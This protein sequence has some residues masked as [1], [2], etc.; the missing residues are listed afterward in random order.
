VPEGLR[1]N[2]KFGDLS[3]IDGELEQ[4]PESALKSPTTS[5]GSSMNLSEGAASEGTAGGENAGMCIMYI[6]IYIYIY[7]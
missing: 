3:L 7:I 5:T 6:Y 1:S 2:L 4:F